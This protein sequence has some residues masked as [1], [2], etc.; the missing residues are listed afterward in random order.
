[1]KEDK[2]RGWMRME[3]TDLTNDMRQ[4]FKAS[5]VN[6]TQA[7]NYLGWGPGKIRSFLVG[8]DYIKCGKEKKYHVKDISRRLSE[9]RNAH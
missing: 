8:V 7:G 6:M 5:Y 3:R 2:E 4:H 9:C 1:M